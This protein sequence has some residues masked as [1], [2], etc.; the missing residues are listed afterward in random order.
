LFSL[1][2]LNEEKMMKTRR[3]LMILAV[4]TTLAQPLLAHAFTLTV[5]A[6][7]DGRDDLIL[8]GNTAQWL[9]LDYAAVGRWNF[10]DLPTYFDGV[11]WTPDWP[12][13]PAPNEIR[14]NGA[15]SSTF[16]GLS[17][18]LPNGT[19]NVALTNL[20][21]GR[22][23]VSI[24]QYPDSS[25]AYTLKVEF[26]DNDIGLPATSYAGW[27]TV[28]LNI[29]PVPE[30]ESYALLLAGLGLVGAAVRWRQPV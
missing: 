25:N 27:Y 17:Y 9:H 14:V 3:Y 28:Q 30:P 2:V 16:S 24:V 22:G 12:G 19:M 10:Q 11:A 5:E 21:S 7:I 26:N 8:Q 6:Y 13:Y 15:L 29:T 1:S 18:A 20:T 4:S 23:P